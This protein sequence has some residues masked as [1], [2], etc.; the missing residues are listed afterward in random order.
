[1]NIDHSMFC[2]KE[3]QYV[4]YTSEYLVTLSGRTSYINHIDDLAH[5]KFSILLN[6]II[7][8]RF[9]K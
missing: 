6:K 7:K 4:K 5:K 2:I 1:M 8:E 3:S 9:E